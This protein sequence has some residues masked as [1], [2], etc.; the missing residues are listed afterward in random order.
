MK[1]CV[2]D[3][4]QVIRT[5]IINKLKSILPESEI[6]DVGFGRHA[7]DNIRLVKPDLVFLDIRMP[8][9]DGLELLKALKNSDP[10]MMVA[11]LTGYDEF[12][13]AR[14]ALQLGALDYLLKPADLDELQ[15][16]TDKVGAQLQSKFLHE[17]EPF[18]RT[19]A[20]QFIIID[21]IQCQAVNYWFNERL[22]KGIWLGDSKEKERFIHDSQTKYVLHFSVNHEYEGLVYLADKERAED[23]FREKCDFITV[24]KQLLNRCE[25]ERFFKGATNPLKKMNRKQLNHKAAALRKSI[26]SIMM[27]LNKSSLASLDSL[28]AEWLE[29]LSLL[30]INLIK[31]ECAHMMSSLDEGLSSKDELIVMDV[32]KNNY[33]LKWI[34][35]H[36]TWDE[37]QER[38]RKFLMDGFLA[39]VN[40]KEKSEAN[41]N[42]SDSWLGVVEKYL[43]NSKDLYVGLDE[44]ASYANVHPVTLSRLFKQETGMTFVRYLTTRRLNKA[45]ELLL[46]SNKK[47][48]EIAEEVGYMNH[49]HFRT[50][51]KTE[52]GHNP[53]E[54]RQMNGVTLENDD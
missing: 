16:I 48:R 14:K 19:L 8:Q 24:F 1:I 7:L 50:I 13:Y 25:T 12:E 51:F 21:H 44:I 45:K 4:E 40:L 10:D 28:V 29:E 46:H 33:W 2:A 11:M 52:F 15:A 6:Y 32:D 35:Q 18:Q 54:Y 49:P 17:F 9:L 31:K 26:I 34:N 3:D 43:K 22:P 39:L 20:S 42:K 30:E 23:V 5:S 38:L 53:K 27:D 37:L 36:K 47:I 41:N